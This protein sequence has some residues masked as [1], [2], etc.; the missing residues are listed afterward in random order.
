MALN[1]V[2]KIDITLLIILLGIIITSSFL[3]S[4]GNRKFVGILG[5]AVLACA[6]IMWRIFFLVRYDTASSQPKEELL[7]FNLERLQGKQPP[8]M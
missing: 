5:I 6:L 2:L 1:R 4:V 3:I 8:R 7:D